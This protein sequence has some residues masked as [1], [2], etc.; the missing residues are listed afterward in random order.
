M[1]TATTGFYANPW[2]LFLNSLL[3]LL[4]L[5]NENIFFENRQTQFASRIN[6]PPA[7]VALHISYKKMLV[8][9]FSYMENASH[10]L[11]M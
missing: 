4:L 11:F 9:Q 8:I 5:L 1:N 3:S 10:T 2:I 6:L 7:I